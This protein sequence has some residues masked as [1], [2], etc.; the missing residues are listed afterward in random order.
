MKRNPHKT[1]SVNNK[2]MIICFTDTNKHFF[3]KFDEPIYQ[4]HPK[5]QEYDEPVFSQKQQ[6]M[7]FEAIYGLSIYPKSVVKR[8]P[9]SVI[10][11][12]VERN[13][14][15]QKVI[16]HLKQEIVNQRIS[17]LFNRLFPKS[18]ITKQ[19]IE[20]HYYDSVR[21][22][23]S[24]RDLRLTEEIIAKRLVSLQLLPNNFFSL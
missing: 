19:I 2:G 16:N 11:K 18:A 17:S 5:Y 12:I 10:N 7:Y 15:V 23:I 6:K 21:C 4:N 1:V 22:P 20:D 13:K 3:V 8:M 14:M 9:Q 24:V